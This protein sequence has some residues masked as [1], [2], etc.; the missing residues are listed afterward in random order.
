MLIFAGVLALELA[1]SLIG[2]K[3]RGWEFR[4]PVDYRTPG[5][6]DL[7]VRRSDLQGS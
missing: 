4:P 6:P 7:D 3:V 5:R 1:R 2:N